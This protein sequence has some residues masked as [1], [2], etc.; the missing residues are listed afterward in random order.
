[1]TKAKNKRVCPVERAGGLD[2]SFR[3]LLQEPQK[4]LKP[5]IFKGMTVLDL[6]CGP[7]FF[8]V[9]IARMVSDTG[10]VIAVDLQDGMLEKVSQKIK[11]TDLE[12]RIKLHKCQEEEIGV[13]DKVDF[14]LAFYM[15][16][17]VPNQESLFE[18][19]RSIL[20]PEGKLLIVEPKF[21]VSEKAFDEMI[22]KLSF[23]GFEIIE[24]PKVFLSRSIVLSLIKN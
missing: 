7:G 12:K 2:N 13:E 18:E 20:K 24:K 8:A 5:Y 11:G 9:E 4:I 22:K 15:I 3:K 21:H 10:Q 14:I 16:H 1:M 6:G 19:L 17:E 23:K